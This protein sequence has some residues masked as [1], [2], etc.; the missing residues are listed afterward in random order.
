[1]TA[2]TAFEDPL[3]RTTKGGNASS[4][5]DYELLGYDANSNVTSF[6]NRA[7]QSIGL[8][9]DGSTRSLSKILP[10]TEPD[11]T[12]AYD[13]LSRPISAL[14]T[15]NALGF[16]W[17]ALSRKT[18][19]GGPLGTSTFGYD[20]A[21]RRTSIVYPST[22]ALTI[23]YAYLTTGELDT[24]KQSGTALATYGYDDVGYRTSVTFA[25]GAAQAFTPDP[26]SRLSQLT[27]NLSGTTNDLTATLAYNPASQITST[28][29]TGDAYAWTGHG[30]GSTAFVQNG[31]NQ[32]TSIGG[33]AASWDT[34]GNLVTEPQ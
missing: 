16:G 13:N 19:E 15:G 24:I 25:N 6:Q 7:A 26:V 10:G 22:T 11:V 18:S 33:V 17:D 23:D 4:T 20:L 27:N 30:N 29:R 14:Q 1:M 34:K 32:Q 8:T 31:L 2:S 5:T 12:Y 28:V 9:Y 21:G 3:S